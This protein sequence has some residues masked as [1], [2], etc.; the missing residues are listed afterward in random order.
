MTTT[1]TAAVARRYIEL[2]GAHDLAPLDDL[3]A[4]DLVARVGDDTLGKQEWLAALGRFLPALVRNDIRSVF[5][6]GEQAAV[7][8]GFV[9][10]TGAGTVP[11][12]E[13]LTVTGERIHSIELIF[14][15]LHWAEVMAA[16]QQRAGR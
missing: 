1:S 5:A 10:D 14:E 8:Y 6:D 11:C 12:V 16:L 15:R 7:V 3:F 2:V 13:L 4:D 9:T